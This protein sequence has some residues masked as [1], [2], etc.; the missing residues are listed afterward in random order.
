[1][2]LLGDI[3]SQLCC[4]CRVPAHIQIYMT[5]FWKKILTH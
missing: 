2:L 5:E 4:L 1:M 3:Q